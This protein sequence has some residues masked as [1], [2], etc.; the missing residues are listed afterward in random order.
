MA[1]DER[2]ELPDLLEPAAQAGDLLREAAR[3]QRALRDEEHLVD[4]ER[5]GE[6]IVGAALHGL[7]GG[8]HRSVR[9]HHDDGGIRA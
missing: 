7:D 4:V 2:A 6:V 5:L 8:L 1:A 9:R 3:R